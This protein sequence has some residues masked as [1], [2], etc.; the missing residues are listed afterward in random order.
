[1]NDPE[2]DIHPLDRDY[3]TPAPE[4]KP[5]ELAP[6]ERLRRFGV[7]VFGVAF[8]LVFLS[9]ITLGSVSGPGWLE[10]FG[11]TMYRFATIGILVGG[12]M[13]L[14]SYRLSMIKKGTNLISRKGARRAA[15]GTFGLL[16]VCNVVFFVLLLALSGLSSASRS[17][18]GLLLTYN[19]VLTIGCGLMVTMIV[20][21]RGIVRA[22]AIGVLV[23]MLFNGLGLMFIFNTGFRS[24]GSGMMVPGRL[25]TIQIC[26]LICA[27][28]VGLVF[29][30]PTSDAS[31]QRGELP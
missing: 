8:A 6:D 15:M 24:G 14:V 23:G 11:S 9:A 2:Y 28:Y 1:M 16:V 4:S 12:I 30:S 22:Y 13:I 5:R 18:D 20:W 25:A 26:G 19:A 31:N 21:H 3:S 27:G 29:P 7:I 10:S 17:S